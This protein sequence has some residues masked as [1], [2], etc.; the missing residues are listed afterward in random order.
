MGDKLE[1]LALQYKHLDERIDLLLEQIRICEDKDTGDKLLHS[2]CEH[3]K[4]AMLVLAA[5]IEL[6]EAKIADY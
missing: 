1:N 2:F 6:L 4:T 3:H 5:R